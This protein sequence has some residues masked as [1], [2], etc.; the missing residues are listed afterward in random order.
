NRMRSERRA[1]TLGRNVILFNDGIGVDIASWLLF[2]RRFPENLNGTDF[3]PRYLRGTPHSL[4][5]FL[6][7]ARPGV[8]ERAAR[9]LAREMP[10]HSCV[11]CRN[12]YMEP[13]EGQD[14][15]DEIRR[16]RADVLLVAMG[17]LKQEVWLADHFA[18]TGCILG[19]GVGGLFDFVAGV[20]PRAPDS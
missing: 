2:G 5:I 3:V 4:R 13:D 6:L 9:A 14:V 12:G 8:A 10:Q 7:G 18:A 16:A 20:V 1:G 17:N 19:F 11:G 15:I